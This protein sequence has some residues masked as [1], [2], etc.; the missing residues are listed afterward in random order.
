ML[1]RLKHTF[2]LNRK[3]RLIKSGLKKTNCKSGFFLLL[4]MMSWLISNVALGQSC[5]PVSNIRIETGTVIYPYRGLHS[6]EWFDR[7][8][9]QFPLIHSLVAQS[10]GNGTGSEAV[11]A[12]HLDLELSRNRSSV[13]LLL[14][15]AYLLNRGTSYYGAQAQRDF[16]LRNVGKR[17]I[18]I[19]S[20]RYEGYVIVGSFLSRLYSKY[21][22]LKHY[23]MILTSV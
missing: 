23:C 9:V 18:S 6:F 8:K 22:R 11:A 19:D 15:K 10:I 21:R 1:V 4:L 12:R 14:T 2:I 7:A 16:T 20:T 3:I 13:D 5:L 17:L